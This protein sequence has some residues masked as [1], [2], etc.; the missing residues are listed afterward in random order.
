MKINAVI[1]FYFWTFWFQSMI[2]VFPI[3]SFVNLL[4]CI[5]NQNDIIYIRRKFLFCIHMFNVCRNSIPNFIFSNFRCY[6]WKL[7]LFNRATVLQ[8]FIKHR[9]NSLKQSSNLQRMFLH[10]NLF[11]ILPFYSWI[12]KYNQKARFRFDFMIV[13]NIC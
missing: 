13:F 6:S 5:W 2:Q 1:W 12:T 7:L 3:R 4:P 10:C 9:V 11:I 8:S